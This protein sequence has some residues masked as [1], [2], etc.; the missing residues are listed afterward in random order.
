[1]KKTIIYLLI[2]LS[3]MFISC[4]LF[5]VSCSNFKEE[6]QSWGTQYTWTSKDSQGELIFY[7]YLESDSPIYGKSSFYIQGP[8][9]MSTFKHKYVQEFENPEVKNIER[10]N[11]KIKSITINNKKYLNTDL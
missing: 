8:I 11:G 2:L 4:D 3:L 6:P 9:D 1:M 5:P 7:T 10:V